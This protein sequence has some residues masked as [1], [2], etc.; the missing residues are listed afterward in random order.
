MADL[1]HEHRARMNAAQY[2]M[3][4]TLAA[5][6]AQLATSIPSYEGVIA[7]VE[8][9]YHDEDSLPVIA[10]ANATSTRGATHFTFQKSNVAKHRVDREVSRLGDSFTA[11]GREFSLAESYMNPAEQLVAGIYM[12][13]K[14]NLYDASVYQLAFTKAKEEPTREQLSAILEGWQQYE[15]RLKPDLATLYRESATYPNGSIGDALFIKAPVTP[16]AFIANWDLSGS[17]ERAMSDYPLLRDTLTLLHAQ[18][19]DIIESRGGK[20]VFPTGDGA[21]F[22]LEIPPASRLSRDATRAIALT[23]FLPMLGEMAA[24]ARYAEV[25]VRFAAEVGRLEQTT[26]NKSGRVF[27]DVSEMSK[28]TSRA[29]T[30]IALGSKLNTLLGLN[31][32]SSPH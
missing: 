15:E 25:P 30:A 22:T 27:F 5:F 13:G 24:V 21:T 3:R 28:E 18:F 14:A 7:A 11:E 6:T 23:A 1:F 4:E 31:E 26:L 2:S 29:Q 20:N 32:T 16:N 8:D 12:P 9:A 17:S 10:V 19:T